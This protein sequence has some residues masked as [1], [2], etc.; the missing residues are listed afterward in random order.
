MEENTVKVVED[1]VQGHISVSDGTQFGQ[2]P[3]NN[4]ILIYFTVEVCP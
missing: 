2:V 4:S 1:T 3:H